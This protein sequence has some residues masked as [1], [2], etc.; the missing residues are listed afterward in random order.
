M[1]R[2]ACPYCCT[3]QTFPE[4]T[5]CKQCGNDVPTKYLDL[6]RTS[7][8]VYLSV[9][10]PTSVGKTT[11]LRSLSHN[12]DNIGKISQGAF[13][14]PLDDN[15]L[16][17]MKNI[18]DK[19]ANRVAATPTVP[20]SK[21]DALRKPQEPLIFSLKSFMT[22]Q[23]TKQ[24]RNLLVMYDIAGEVFENRA[25][26][27]QYAEPLKLA[28]TIW[29]VVSL[30]DLEHG[31]TN[32]NTIADVFNIYATGMERV[33]ARPNERKLH[34]IYTKA[35][36]LL[37][38]LPD[39]I[40]EYVRDDPYF[41]LA[42][43]KPSEFKAIPFSRDDYEYGLDQLSS[44]L[45]DYT[46]DDVNGGLQFIN[47]VR[48]YGMEL[49]FSINTAT[50]RDYTPRA[51]IIDS[52]SYR[53]LD[54]LV[55]A[56]RSHVEI[57]PQMNLSGKNKSP[58][59]RIPIALIL[60]TGFSSKAKIY[61]KH[62]Q[63]HAQFFSALSDIGDVT[64]YYTGTLTPMT[65]PGLEPVINNIPKETPSLIGPILDQLSPDALILVVTSRRIEDLQDFHIP[66]WHKCMGVITFEAIYEV[67]K[68]DPWPR[69][70]VFDRTTTADGQAK[71]LVKKLFIN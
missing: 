19:I 12:M 37:N 40:R 43:R 42:E 44:R 31:K 39:D 67:R 61:D 28:H 32:Y 23:E 54:P 7:A 48:D 69:S 13:L 68:N 10:G 3:I 38:I 26:I 56:L 45:E 21:E 57:Q 64:T 46:M 63:L 52:D 24:D 47:M 58:N 9:V 70:V 65:Q 55:W 60:D 36:K 50:G 30:H 51:Q 34:V 18:R 16:A 49:S 8:P 14:D 41:N 25:E 11:F 1:S 22:N 33:G 62:A 17:E 29:F 53:V 71:D 20:R 66:E 59:M 35:D 6:A 2:I 5:K 15:T 27:E 4:G